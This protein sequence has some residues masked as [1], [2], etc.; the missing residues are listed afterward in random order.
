VASTGEAVDDV[1]QRAGEAVEDTGQTAKRTAQGASRTAD[2]AGSGAATTAKRTRRTA[3]AQ[4]QGATK[5]RGRSRESQGTKRSSR[6]PSGPDPDSK[7]R[8][9]KS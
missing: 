3:P 9:R 7:R 8:S 1:G 4:E 6:Q 5:Q 2:K